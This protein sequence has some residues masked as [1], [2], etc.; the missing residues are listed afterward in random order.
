MKA[1]LTEFPLSGVAPLARVTRSGSLESLHLGSIAVVDTT[2]RIL[3]QVG[4]SDQAVFW[5][6]CA[7]LHQAVALLSAEGAQQFQ[8]TDEEVAV[9]CASHQGEPFQVSRVESAL[10]KIGLPASA[11]HCGAQEP[12]GKIPAARLVC[13]GEAPTPLH[14]T[15]SGNH[16]GLLALTRLLGGQ[17]ER[18]ESADAPAQRRALEIAAQFCGLPPAEIGLGV[19]GC[20]IPAYRTPLRALAVAFA[21]LFAPPK[22]DAASLAR[23]AERVTRAVTAHPDLV[24]GPGQLDTEL[25]RAFGGDAIGKFGAEA[26]FAAALRPSSRWPQGLG[27]AIKVA[28]GVGNRARDVALLACVEQLQLGTE[29]QRAALRS[30]VE[31]R[32]RTRR[33]EVVGAIEPAFEL[34]VQRV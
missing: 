20:S 9:I 2:G 14:N 17:T 23:A 32:V 10:T 8:F 31:S 21:R 25:I 11:L 4:D 30:H 15:C 27:I 22:S 1:G 18:Y 5:R 26:V 29:S 28:D 16:A 7:K 34:S 33:G 12:Y 6:S 19:D 13:S 24:G 3:A